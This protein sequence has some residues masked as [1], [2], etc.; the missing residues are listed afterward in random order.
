MDECLPEATR[1]GVCDSKFHFRPPGCPGTAAYREIENKVEPG[2][3]GFCRIL[4]GNW[5]QGGRRPSLRISVLQ[6]F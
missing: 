2:M 3:G 4:T 5:G 6:P 1:L